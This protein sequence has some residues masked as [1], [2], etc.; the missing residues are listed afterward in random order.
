M[1]DDEET[2]FALA[3]AMQCHLMLIDFFHALLASQ[4][5]FLWFGTLCWTASP[6]ENRFLREE[7]DLELYV[8]PN[9]P[10]VPSSWLRRQ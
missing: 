2:D 7:M 1:L 10:Q 8:A 6:V 3:G 5:M 9:I 4:A